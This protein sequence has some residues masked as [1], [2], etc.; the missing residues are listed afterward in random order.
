MYK[1]QLVSLPIVCLLVLSGCYPEKSE[2]NEPVSSA[3]THTSK[4]NAPASEVLLTI[5]GVP[6][7]T[8]DDFDR[9]KD[10]FFTIQPQ[11]K[12]VRYLIGR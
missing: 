4:S 8:I 2:K 5:N 1:K 6:K 12:I 3:E 7:L 9:Y 11:Y 10:Q